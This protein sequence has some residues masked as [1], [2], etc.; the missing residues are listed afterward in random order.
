MKNSYKK[1]TA[2]I[3]ALALCMM[4][5]LSACGEKE[6]ELSDAI[7]I[8]ALNG[9]TGMGLIELTDN[10]MVSLETYQ[11]PDEAVQKL[12]SGDIDVACL[13]SNMGAVLDA[14]TEGNVEVLA[15]VVNGVLWLVE[16]EGEEGLTAQS[17]EELKGKTIIASGK[18]GTPEYVLQ[19]LLENAGLKMGEDV[20]VEWM[21]AHADVAQKLM[22]TEGAFALLPE[23]FASTV[24]SK[25]EKVEAAVDMNDAWM[26]M[27]GKE[28]PM[29]I[30]VAKKDFIESRPEDVEAL[31]ELVNESVETV[32]EGSDEVAE[33][34]VEA[35][36]IGDAELCKDV[37]PRL[38]L[39]CLTGEENKET[40]NTFYETLFKMNSAAVGGNMPADGLYY[41]VE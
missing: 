14:K 15:T 28:L 16:N 4:P 30:L 11:A 33:K 36:F 8:G 32:K 21:D 41:G 5:M 17:M 34:L 35:G 6:A 40:L 19:A 20:Q 7:R 31:L 23:P 24:L 38:S 12:I 22:S 18:G 29:G 26:Q 25:S 10:E 37:I 27:T 2:L 13:P 1:M 39:T 3:L 9:P